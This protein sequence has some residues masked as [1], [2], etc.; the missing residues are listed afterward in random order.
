MCVPSIH[1]LY[2]TVYILYMLMPVPTF[3]VT[4]HYRSAQQWVAKSV[5]CMAPYLVL[6]GVLSFCGHKRGYV[7]CTLQR[8]LTRLVASSYGPAPS[9]CFCIAHLVVIRLVCFCCSWLPLRSPPALHRAISGSYRRV[10]DA[11]LISVL[12]YELE[13]LWT[14]SGL[15]TPRFSSWCL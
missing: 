4:A 8:S 14:F 6:Q 3:D 2:Q 7:Y 1:P 5:W 9:C 11:I 10:R 15:P 12:V 13:P